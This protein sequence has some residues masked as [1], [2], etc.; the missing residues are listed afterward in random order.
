MRLPDALRQS[1]ETGQVLGTGVHLLEPQI[2]IDRENRLEIVAVAGETGEVQF[3]DLRDQAD[4]RLGSLDLSVLVVEQ[5]EQRTQVFAVSGPHVAAVPAS[6]EPVDVREHR[7]CTV[8]AH[9]LGL[10]EDVQPVLRVAALRVGHER[11]HGHGVVAQLSGLAF[12]GRG[13]LR[14]EG[15]SVVDPFRGIAEGADQ[16]L[17]VTDTATEDHGVDR[18]TA[19]NLVVGC[20]VGDVGE[21]GGEAGVGVCPL[22]ALR[23]RTLT[24]HG[25]VGDRFTLPIQPSVQIFRMVGGPALPPHLVGLRVVGDVG[26]QRS[27]TFT[28]GVDRGRIGVA[29]GV[30]GHTEGTELRVH[31]VE[32]TVDTHAQPHDVIAVEEHLVAV[33]EAVR[34]KHHGEVRL[35]GG[36]REST[37]DV[38]VFAGDL[39][40]DADQHELLGEELPG[41][42]AVVA[43]LTKAVRDLSEQR[44]AAVGG[45]VVEDGALVGDRREAAL[46]VIRA[47]AEILQVSGDVD[48]ADEV[49]RVLEVAE[50]VD[51]DP[52]HPD[53]VQADGPVVGEFDAGGP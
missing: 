9:L 30:G 20:D 17:A 27:G 29:V 21:R 40:V 52:G 10:I 39:V 14:A 19:G 25:T 33:P 31:A 12:R 36:R 13:G 2:A 41:G 32:P 1:L 5:P 3:V 43:G 46:V 49:V 48:G 26:E 16:R 44:V 18:H 51:P 50:V 34:G 42:P 35:A 6:L 38:A 37:A 47:L 8:A 24:L 11:A 28:D 23:V 22:I 53:H 4:R 7:Q 45:A 15:E